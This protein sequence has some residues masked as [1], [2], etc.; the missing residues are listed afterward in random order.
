MSSNQTK[1]VVAA[2]VIVWL[3]VT[4]IALPIFFVDQVFKSIEQLD[5][6][7][8]AGEITGEEYELVLD[9]LLGSF[10]GPELKAIPD[11]VYDPSARF[12]AP[13]VPSQR[14]PL[15]ALSSHMLLS[16]DDD[17]CSRVDHLL[18]GNQFAG[19]SLDL[20]HPRA[21]SS[22]IRKRS[23]RMRG[24]SKHGGYWD[25]VFG[26]FVPELTSRLTSG[27][28]GVPS[29]LRRRDDFASSFLFPSRSF[30]NGIYIR[31]DLGRDGRITGFASHVEGTRHFRSS[32]ATFVELDYHR[33]AGG[34][35]ILRQTLG[36]F[37]HG[38][39]TRYVLSPFIHYG[40][41]AW[42]FK[43]E[44]SVIANGGAAL[45]FS[46]DWRHPRRIFEII[47]F[48]YGRNYKNVESGGY[49]YADYGTTEIPEIDFEYSDKRTGRRGVAIE[50]EY[51]LS[52]WQKIRTDLVRWRNV[53]ED[54]DCIAARVNWSWR[55]HDTLAFVRNV[56]L[57]GLWEDFDLATSAADARQWLTGSTELRLSGR[58]TAENL[59]RVGM[60]TLDGNDREEWRMR[61]EM[62]AVIRKSLRVAVALDWRDS[63]WSVAS[64]EKLLMSISE[65]FSDG[66]GNAV[67][68]TVLTRYYPERRR[69]DDWECR[70]DT[71][72]NF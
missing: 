43:G 57:Q 25:A 10:S 3:P 58:L 2:L 4:S 32:F 22:T 26:S 28:S 51:Q 36:E 31:S 14:P 5:E 9:L 17:D 55:D 60:R 46:F 39:T 59:V 12:R 44:S 70:L 40:N 35:G 13:K 68:V 69:V 8:A 19:A 50:T 61:Q 6:A 67:S 71:K 72:L 37:G 38:S 63:D 24:R 34:L 33:P 64:N 47:A 45:Q 27:A 66:R 16:L 52:A 15:V 42:M 18:I 30:Q 21:G 48:S 29:A 62:E 56:R 49:A 65:R 23:V 11:G 53:L 1:W 20:D 41:P 7:L 54:R